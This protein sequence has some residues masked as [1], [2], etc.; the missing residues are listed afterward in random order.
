MMKITL[1]L[2]LADWSNETDS[3]AVVSLLQAYALHPMGGAEPLAE[4][5]VHNL[6]QSHWQNMWY[7]IY[8][9]RW[10]QRP[11]HFQPLPGMLMKMD[12]GVR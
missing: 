7:T 11:A 6:P 4:Y 9:L 12:E 1:E 5:V 2:S 10:P 3:D 8:R